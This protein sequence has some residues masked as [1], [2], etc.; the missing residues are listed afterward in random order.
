M[1]RL[2]H[3]AA[4]FLCLTLSVVLFSSCSA[5]IHH[6][7]I[8]VEGY[9]SI[10]IELDGKTAPKTVRNFIKLAEEGFYDGLTFPPACAGICTPGRRTRTATVPAVQEN[11]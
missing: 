6:A 7:E 2:K 9:G 11:R 10:F 3:V 5:G 8:V 1:R 4:L